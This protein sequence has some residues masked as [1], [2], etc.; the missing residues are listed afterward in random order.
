MKW[1]EQVTNASPLFGEYVEE[2]LGNK[3][4]RA[5]PNHVVMVPSDQAKNW[6]VSFSPDLTFRGPE[7]LILL[8]PRINSLD[9]ICFF[10]NGNPHFDDQN[11]QNGFQNQQ[12]GSQNRQRGTQNQQSGTQNQQSGKARINKSGRATYMFS[13]WMASLRWTMSLA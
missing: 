13:S 3:M 9:G 10:Q 4:S 11:Q 2:I 1:Y 6:M 7:L 8:K 5:L 12:S